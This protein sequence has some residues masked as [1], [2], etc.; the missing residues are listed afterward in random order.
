MRQES[1]N[2]IDL[3][4]RQ[5]GRR[6]EPFSSELDAQHLDADELSSYVA[7]ALPAA[8]RARYTAHLAD[9]SSCRK[10][11]AQLS[12]AEGVVAARQ[13]AS[14]VAPS[15]LKS[16]LASLFSP[17][18]LRYAI[19][20]LGVIVIAVVGI[21]MV[22]Q[23]QKGSSVAL[24]ADTEQN[25]SVALPEATPSQGLY[26]ERGMAD[27]VAADKDKEVPKPGAAAPA[28]KDA[29][30]D[31]RGVSSSDAAGA[32]PAAPVQET[33]PVTASEPPP[34]P[35]PAKAAAAE[36]SER[37]QAEPEK[38]KVDEVSRTE[39]ATAQRSYDGVSKEADDANKVS[40]P[41]RSR[42][43]EGTGTGAVANAA[44]Q[45][46]EE[47]KRMR[48]G[49][50]SGTFSAAETRTVAGREFR[51]NGNVWID[52]AYNGGQSV[53]VLTR[54]SD[55][56]RSLVEDEPAIHTIAETLKTEF[57]VIWKSRAYRV[58]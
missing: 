49:E 25:K 46:R 28:A 14:V 31:A 19:P 37:K 55:Q 47:V 36:E 41:Q 27:Q 17:L 48:K 5:L 15:G 40:G 45:S 3:L 8:A 26:G 18:V 52:T 39:V 7:N 2:G 54:D 13:P 24:R 12:A 50:V 10:M 35:A 42:M 4:L 58:R 30:R 23:E 38:K 51:K 34:S 22:R 20:A 9:C 29:P 43:G 33:Q 32:A 21:V 44:P 53:T 57:I 56:Y 6:D 16:F 1:N 11:V